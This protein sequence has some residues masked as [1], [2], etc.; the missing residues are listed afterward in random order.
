MRTAIQDL[1]ARIIAQYTE[2][3]QQ[4]EVDPAAVLTRVERFLAILQDSEG[5]GGETGAVL[6]REMLDL[7]DHGIGLLDELIDW[8]KNLGLEQEHQALQLMI[9]PLALLVIRRGLRLSNL[10]SIVNTLS[11][12][13]N[14]THHPGQLAELAEVM[15]EIINAVAPQVHQEPNSVENIDPPQPWRMLNLNHAI[16][17]TRTHDTQIME[18]TFQQLMYRLPEDA[19]G[20]FAEGMEQ[21]DIVGYPDHV[22]DMMQKYYELSH[23]PTLH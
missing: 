18:A 10:E 3:G 1:A 11:M 8:A 14:D 20:F 22:R 9:I 23:N 6:S 19:P 7:G 13:A 16:V 12:I 15:E 21:M 17:A 2:S 4:A 5:T